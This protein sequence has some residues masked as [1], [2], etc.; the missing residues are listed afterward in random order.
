M[1]RH[2]RKEGI[3]HFLIGLFD[4]RSHL[5]RADVVCGYI[6]VS[7]LLAWQSGLF[8]HFIFHLRIVDDLGHLVSL[9]G[10]LLLLVDH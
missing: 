3:L 7:V 9:F 6:V 2:D 4:F 8:L 1:L 5:V 10:I